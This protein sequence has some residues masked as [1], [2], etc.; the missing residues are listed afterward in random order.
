MSAPANLTPLFRPRTV[1]VIG[2]SEQRLNLGS[3][4]LRNLRLFGFSGRLLAIHPRA[5]EIQGVPAVPSIGDIDGPIDYAYVALPADRIV[6]FLDDAAGRIGIAHVVAGGFSEVGNDALEIEL[7]AAAARGG[8][9]VLGPNCLGAYIPAA[10]LTFVDGAPREAG[11]VAMTSQSGGL[12]GDVIRAGAA[13]GLRFSGVVTV[14]NCADIGFPDL[15]HHLAHD[16]ATTVVGAYVESVRDGAAFIDALSEVRTAKPVV[17]LRGGVTEPGRRSAG[18]HTGAMATGLR[19]WEGLCRQL[20]V[21]SVRT[22]ESFLDVLVALRDSRRR[23]GN[24]LVVLGP[25]GGMSVLASDAAFRAGF[26]LP[27][28]DPITARALS[29]LGIATG[30][31]VHNPI[32]APIGA[33]ATRDGSS[34]DRAIAVIDRGIA[35]DLIVV[36]LNLYGFLAFAEQGSSVVHNLVEGTVTARRRG[37]SVALVLRSTGEPAVE[38]LRHEVQERATGHSVPVFYS[39]EAALNAYALVGAIGHDSSRKSRKPDNAQPGGAIL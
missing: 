16:T 12:G 6:R 19:L 27:P 20:G 21:L 36:H 35:P 22:L 30:G 4:A 26:T 11:P 39:I 28:T 2:A 24:R 37:S 9:R 38:M 8:I 15:M 25:G 1:I 23:A 31:G 13:R 33:L 5:S 32:D 3:A 18:S 29:D 17:M 7:V 10:G 14:G 34:L